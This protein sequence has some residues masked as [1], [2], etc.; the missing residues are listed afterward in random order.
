MRNLFVI[1]F[2]LISGLIY[3]QQFSSAKLIKPDGTVQEV[4]L[5]GRQSSIDE[6]SNLIIYSGRDR[7]TKMLVAASEFDRLVSDDNELVIVS[8]VVQGLNN[9][10][11]IALRMLVEG[12]PSLYE[13]PNDTDDT[14]FVAEKEGSFTYL[15]PVDQ[16]K[17]VDSNYLK[18]LSVNANPKAQDFSHYAELSYSRKSLI[19]YFLRNSKGAEQLEGEYRVNTFEFYGLTG[20][21]LYQF[22]HDWLL[23][24][25]EDNSE[26]NF[27]IGVRML[28]NLDRLSNR[29]TMFAG[30]G[31]QT[32]LNFTT[33][34]SA[35]PEDHP[36]NEEVKLNVELQHF[37]SEVGF[38]YNI[39]IDEFK[40]SPFVRAELW[41]PS[42]ENIGFT[43]REGRELIYGGL[44]E[45]FQN[46]NRVF[47]D[48]GL[49]LY[50]YKKFFVSASAG[51]LNNISGDRIYAYEL[52][53]TRFSLLV[54]Y[55]LF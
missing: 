23:G 15:I 1:A 31:Y 21:N 3:G 39:F 41:L 29:L 37:T 6:Q 47:V 13:Y 5:K 54:G 9:N 14:K 50:G 20:I 24:P 22:E 43:G 18:W 32:P 11:P 19:E 7:S 46:Q 4:Y 10:D 51:F 27:G 28:I 45:E 34:G 40:L 30:L 26:T 52:N 38:S 12:N 53:S 36:Y 2:L 42:Q 55:K 33:S 48:V 44:E 25:I 8:S 16:A 35:Y 49:M 17:D